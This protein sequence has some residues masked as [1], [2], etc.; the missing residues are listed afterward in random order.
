MALVWE[1]NTVQNIMQ[2]SVEFVGC[3]TW[4]GTDQQRVCLHSNRQLVVI[5]C[6]AS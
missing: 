4:I 2:P 3:N 5:A 6:V 1:Q